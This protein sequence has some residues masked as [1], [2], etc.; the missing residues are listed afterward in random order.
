MTKILRRSLNHP[1]LTMVFGLTG[2]GKST[3]AKSLASTIIDAVYI[4]KD[5]INESFLWIPK[6]G[7]RDDMLRY[8]PQE[9]IS[10]TSDYYRQSIWIQTYHCMLMLAKQALQLG[11]HPVIDCSYLKEIRWGYIEQVL[12]PQLTDIEYNL[13]IVLIH[14][15]PD[16]IRQRIAKRGN[17]RDVYAAQDE[18]WQALL[19]EQPPVPEEIERYSHIK[20]DNSNGP[21]T[22]DQMCEVLNFLAE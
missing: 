7:R 2:V 21:V 18:N 12:K 16:I 1:T 17:P 20:V 13:K 22:D 6:E 14:A 15:D 8:L 5:T 10:T 9:A 4:D 11:K 3:F 19:R